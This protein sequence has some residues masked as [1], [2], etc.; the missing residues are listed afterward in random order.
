ME[1]MLQETGR[2]DKAREFCDYI[3]KKLR[4]KTWAMGSCLH[5]IG[6][7]V[8]D[9]ND[10]RTKGNVMGT[11]NPGLKLCEKIGQTDFEKKLCATG[12]FNS[13]AGLYSDPIYKL[14]KDDPFLICRKQE[15]SLLSVRRSPRRSFEALPSIQ[16]I[17]LNLILLSALVMIN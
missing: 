15:Q 5:G 12:V 3:D 16:I 1:A 10:P 6:H 14:N 2:L 8:T 17:R 11:I 7:G 4:G 13:L 9:G